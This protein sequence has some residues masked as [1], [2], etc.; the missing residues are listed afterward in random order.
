MYK[1][2]R[3]DILKTLKNTINEELDIS[4][5]KESHI[6]E[7]SSSVAFKLAKKSNKNP[8]DIAERIAKEI[9]K[10][11]I[12][13]IRKVDASKGYINFYIDYNEIVI[14]LLEK[15]RDLG[16]NYGKSE[17]KG[18]KIILEH[19]SLNPSGPIHI[20]RLRNSL[21]GDSL[22]RIL[23]FNGYDVETHYYVNDIGKQVAIIA[24]G[25]LENIK[26]DK[27][28]E[29]KYKGYKDKKDFRIFFEY[30]AANK[31]FENDREFQRRVNELIRKAEFGDEVA[32]NMITETAKECLSGQK[33]I[34][35]ILDIKFDKFDFESELIKNKNV[36]KVIKFLKKSEFA[37]ET[38]I[39]FGLDLSKFGL[40][41]TDNISILSRRDG[42]S[43]YLTRDIAYHLY[44]VGMGDIIINVL[45]EDHKLEFIELKTILRE[46]YKIDKK[47]ESVHFSFVNFEGIELSTR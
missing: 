41:R 34:F 21:I 14:P 11:K 12:F 15:I 23:K 4:D 30:V 46:I 39:G 44:K 10:K 17:K 31:R 47:I 43:V 3:I 16:D 42:T 33:E 37:R 29:K 20:G 38:E 32:L 25:F 2:I 13:G 1:K 45:G 18:E 6:A 8:R 7:F 40:K 19:S 24:E 5:I 9:D 26:P 36:E 22:Y 35:E 27:E 28:I